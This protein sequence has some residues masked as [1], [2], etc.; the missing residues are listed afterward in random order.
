[1]L[2]TRI[3]VTFTVLFAFVFTY[4]HANNAKAKAV[5]EKLNGTFEYTQIDESSFD[6][7]FE[8]NQ[9]ITENDPNN[10]FLLVNGRVVS[11]GQ[12]GITIDPPKAFYHHK[13][14]GSVK[15]FVGLKFTILKALDSAKVVSE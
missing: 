2:K 12:E 8:I 14:S 6:V 10:Y 15:D 1:M 3:I 13:E 4:S 5:F 9:G 7:N 11:F